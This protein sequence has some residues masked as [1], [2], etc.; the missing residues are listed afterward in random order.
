MRET[1]LGGRLIDGKIGQGGYKRVVE[2]GGS[3]ERKGGSS[4]SSLRY[5]VVARGCVVLLP[6]DSV[7]GMETQDGG[8]DHAGREW[9]P[10]VVTNL[11]RLKAVLKGG[12]MHSRAS[13]V[14]NEGRD[15]EVGDNRTMDHGC[16]EI[17][18]SIV[19]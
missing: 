8:S 1:T 15:H 9:P 13:T 5:A 12:W 2:Q 4:G 7:R 3:A 17:R 11:E 18:K 10:V 14:E 6:R 16:F 19:A